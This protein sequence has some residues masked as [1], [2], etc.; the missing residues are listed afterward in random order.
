[1]AQNGR[2]GERHVAILDD[3]LERLAA[4]QRVDPGEA[5]VADAGHS[6]VLLADGDQLVNGRLPCFPSS[7]NGRFQATLLFQDGLG[8]R[9]HR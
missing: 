7:L 2:D 6:D 3:S 5:P 1:M 9:H 8:S 4:H